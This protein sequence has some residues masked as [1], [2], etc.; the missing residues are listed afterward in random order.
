[1]KKRDILWLILIFVVT[2]ILLYSL[3]FN[4]RLAGHDTLGHT[5]D[6][7]YFSKTINLR[8]IFG[9]NIVELPFHKFGYGMWLFYPKLPHLLGSYLYLITDNV[10][11]S[12]N[13]IYFVVISCNF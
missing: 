1:M 2:C 13:I 5:S 10:Y 9:V 4:P 11:L 6:I 12:M 7:I 8:H 3:F